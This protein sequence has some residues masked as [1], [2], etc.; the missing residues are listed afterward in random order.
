MNSAEIRKRFLDFFAKNG[1]AIIP[2]ASLVTPDEKGITNAT[3]FNTAGMQPL[4]PYLL[5]K[6][7]PLGKRL[8][9][10]QK[11]I[12]TVDIDD[13]GDKTHATFFEML[14]NWSLGDY[15][16]KEAINW[17]FELLT[18]KK[19]GF[20]LDPNR[21]YVTVFMGDEN[22]PRDE[23][24]ADIWKEVFKKNGIDFGGD[25]SKGAS[26]RIF[27]LPAAKNWWE[28]GD[29]GPC[30]PDTEMFY[31]VSNTFKGRTLTHAEYVQADDVRDVVE[32][33]NDVFMQFEKKDGKII[34]NLPKPSV[35]TGAGLERLTM[36]MQGVD[37]IFDTDLFKPIMDLMAKANNT[38]RNKRIIADHLRSSVFLIADG[39]R[40]SN[41]DRGY[42]LRRLIRRAVG[43]TT[44]KKLD[45][46]RIGIIVDTVAGIY[47]DSYPYLGEQS[48][49][50]KKVLNE[51]CTKFAETLEHGLK[52]FEKIVSRGATNISGTEAF[53]LYQS[54]GFPIDM[55]VELAKEKGITVA[56]AQFQEEFKKHQDLSRAGAE[57]K[58]KGGLADANDPQVVRYHT[59]THL[60]HQALHDVLGEG[61]G[62]K[63]SN[64]TAERLRFDFSYGTKM[65][66]EQ[67]KQVEA[68]VNEK[69]AAHLPVQQVTLPRAEAEKTGARHFFGEKYGEQI[70]IYFIGNDLASAY[71]KEFCGGPHVKNT[72]ELAG[73]EGTWKFKLQKEEASSQGV[74]RIKAVLE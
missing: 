9:D 43:C 37:N 39:V 65:T 73:P 35:D 46:K 70:S 15:F 69:I 18:D 62:Q 60:L 63:G 50:I 53:N 33:W 40:P 54:F 14:G 5:G 30:G 13:I 31:D 19:S 26:G 23:E 8:A 47:K 20:G 2:S 61:V 45:E 41:T 3:L 36:T 16:K 32:V 34:G 11:C 64:I 52:E 27:Y 24:A 48:A 51:E 66:D 29:N 17:S 6:P 7:H 57:Q 59:A 38:L 67:K 74:R 1:H 49:E 44:D 25:T 72:S 4:V 22:A 58:F 12:R 71:S 56:T 68:I 55:T 28:A 10:S 21:L 42:I